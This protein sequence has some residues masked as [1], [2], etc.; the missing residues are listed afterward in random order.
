MAALLVTQ[1]VHMLMYV[2]VET[3]MPFSPSP[4][5]AEYRQE[6]FYPPFWYDTANKPSIVN[7]FPQIVGYGV[8]FTIKYTGSV[9]NPNLPVRVIE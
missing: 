2:Q 9:T 5:K 8:R 4:S 6:I 3:D 7:V 1:P